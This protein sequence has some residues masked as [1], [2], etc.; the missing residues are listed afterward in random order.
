NLH[1]TTRTLDGIDGYA[2]L[3]PGLMS[4]AGWAVLDDSRTLLFDDDGWLQPRPTGGVDLYFFGYG[5]DYLGCLQDYCRVSGHMP[6]IPRWALGNWWSRYWAYTQDELTTLIED[7]QSYDLPFSVCI[8]DMDWHITKTGNESTGWTGYTWNRDLFPDPAGFLAFAHAEKLRIGLNLHPAEGIHPHEEQ[9]EDMARALGI[10]P[11]T[12]Q[13]VP[14][15]ITNPAFADAYLKILHHPYEKMGVDFWWLDWQQ[16]LTTD[17][18]GLDPLWLINHLHFYDL[19]RDGSKRPFIFSRWG[20]EGHQR[21]PIGFSGDAYATWDTLQFE[22]YMTATA[23]N[24]AYGWWSHDIGGHVGGVHDAELLARWVQYGVL[25]PINR[26]HATSGLYYDRRPW[27]FEDAEV[28][29]VVREA[30]Q[31]RHALVP[32]LYTMARRASDHSLPLIQPLYYSHPEHEAAYHCPH[33]YWYGSELIAAPFVSPADDRTGLSRQVVWLPAGASDGAPDGGWY[34]VFSGEHYAGERWQ[35]VYGRLADIPLFAKAGAIVPLAG[36]PD[37]NDVTGNPAE[38]DVLVFAGADGSFTLYEDDG[39]TTAYQDDQTCRTT[40]TQAMHGGSLTLTIGAPDGDTSLIPAQRAYRLTIFGVSP[41]ATAR[42]RVN[43]EPVAVA[44]TFDTERE[45]LHVAA[46][47]LGRA[48]ALEIVLTAAGALLVHRDR[49][50]ETLRRMLRFFKLHTGVRSVMGAEIETLIADPTR[51]A[52]YVVTLAPSQARALCEVLF[53]AGVHAIS[54]TTAPT[55]LLL[56]NNRADPAL[57]FRYG[58]AYVH[59]GSITAQHHERGIA[60]RFAHFIPPAHR[61]SHGALDEVVHRT[62]WEV[63]IDYANI[64]TAV[65]SYHEETP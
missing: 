34:H 29:R 22:P 37:T 53:D 58:T 5:H 40:I 61:W 28:L 55:L 31:F 51:L 39:L 62:Q 3:E 36:E 30:L 17:L 43:G 27:I 54:D 56:W 19:G 12:Q 4:R 41:A 38:L 44:T 45:T 1:G 16:G 35:P 50:A 24:V 33:Q 63:Q 59:F 52:S 9:Y 46:I 64:F 18:P 42:A 20:R 7:F 65:E 25:S 47:T 57:T 21:Y 11:A 2:P 8:V 26:L 10:D 32:Y 6:M 23:S 14:F 60:P 49:T 48:G 15:A 13:P